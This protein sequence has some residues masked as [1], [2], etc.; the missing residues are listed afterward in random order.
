MGTSC[1]LPFQAL[2]RDG[3]IPVLGWETVRAV[4]GTRDTGRP[5][6]VR[7]GSEISLRD[8]N[9]VAGQDRDRGR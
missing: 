2:S 5:C 1:L 6:D 8:P 3:E 9:E 4:R 7:I